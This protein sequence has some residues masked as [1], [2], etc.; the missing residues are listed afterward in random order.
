MNP[1]PSLCV[2]ITTPVP[3][4]WLHFTTSSGRYKLYWKINMLV[5]TLKNKQNEREKR[6]RLCTLAPL[7]RHFGQRICF[8]W[9]IY[10][11]SEMGQFV[12]S[13]WHVSLKYNEKFSTS[14][15]EI[16]FHCRGLPTR[17]VI[18]FQYLVLFSLGVLILTSN[19]CQNKSS[20]SNTTKKQTNCFCFWF[21]CIHGKN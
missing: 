2:F 11:S 14:L 12:H 7:P 10:I 6:Q 21:C 9:R 5:S 17:V 20:S 16:L 3:P 8:L 15:L 1:G 19:L 18:Q 13:V 4:H